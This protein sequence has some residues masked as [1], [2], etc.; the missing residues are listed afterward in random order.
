MTAAPETVFTGWSL[1]R[2]E[3]LRRCPREY[4]LHYCEAVGGWEI[5]CASHKKVFLH[6]LRELK[7]KK[8]YVRQTVF[9]VFRELFLAG[10]TEAEKLLQLCLEKCEREFERMLSGAWLEDHRVMMLR[11]LTL[12][13]TNYARF[14]ES[15]RNEIG[16]AAAVFQREAADK[17]LSVPSECRLALPFPLEVETGEVKTYLTPVAAWLKGGIFHVFSAGEPNPESIAL[18]LLYALNFFNCPPGRCR[19]FFFTD[20][21]FLQVPLPESLSMPLRQIHEESRMMIKAVSGTQM[22]DFPR[23]TVH[24]SCCR[25]HPFCGM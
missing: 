18:L 8:W 19:I 6:C 7:E 3:M 5:K 24:C 10:E 21:R 13:E 17:M 22:K 23:E 9:S 20:G 11:E 4:F 25:F 1:R 15:V 14:K 16:A 2:R 12:P